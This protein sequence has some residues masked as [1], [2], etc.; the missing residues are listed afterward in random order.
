M[1]EYVSERKRDGGEVQNLVT[2]FRMTCERKK[3]TVTK[4][5][6]M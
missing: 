3:L 6:V 4:S 5:K 2:G 1:Y